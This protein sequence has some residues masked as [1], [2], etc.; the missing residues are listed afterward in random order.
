[1]PLMTPTTGMSREEREDTVMG[2][3]KACALVQRFAQ[4]GNG[5]A[6]GKTGEISRMDEGGE[7]AE[8]K[9]DEQA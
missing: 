8:T 5:V 7:Q 6:V 3:R 1:M 4:T 9:G 2:R